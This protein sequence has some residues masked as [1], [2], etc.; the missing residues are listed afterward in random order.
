MN[1]AL[2]ARGVPVTV[3]DPIHGSIRI[4]DWALPLVDSPA[5]QRL[6]RIHQL[7]TA[8]H[9]YP[10]AHHR[11]FEHSL[12]AHHLAGR[13]AAALGLSE[14]EACTV[15]AA[16]LLH[17]VG[18]GPFSHAFEEL[19]KDEGRRHEEASMDLVGWGPLADLLRQAGLDPL[20][21]AEAIGGK[22]R[23]APIVSGS[24][25]ADRLDYLL[26]DA[27]YTGFRSAVD[28]DRLI[29]V[30]QPGERHTV[31]L[32]ESG[33]IA[34]E[35]ILTTRFLM[36]PA[37]YLHHTVRATEAMLQAAVR[38]HLGDTGLRLVDLERTTDDELLHRLRGGGG[39][40][41]ALVA[42]MDDRRLYKRAYEGRPGQPNTQ[43]LLALGSRPRDRLSLAAEVADAAGVPHA[44]VLLDVPHPPKFRELR[45]QVRFR[46][47]TLRP[48]PEASRLV[49]VMED[50]R[51]DHWRAW[52]FAPRQDR[53]RVAA[54][55]Q[56]ILD[57]LA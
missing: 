54:A 22:G 34:A 41:A 19:V 56:R 18:H 7:G 9:V 3:R 29:E 21:V 15:R 31:V 52:V 36:Y 46:D 12:G 42:R 40:A 57:A 8:H 4:D 37:V 17:D 2:L 10:G 32:D 14:H 38:S 53:E 30:L 23:L 44:S 35:A 45:L 43:A 50:A 55:A 25:D 27:H 6:R 49:K 20:A 33:L 51:M 1:R 47:G 26:R 39:E 48:L 5:V 24:L 16:C 28:A 11:R 13:F